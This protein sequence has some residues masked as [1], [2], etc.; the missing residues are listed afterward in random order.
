M[1]WHHRW[2]STP[3][4][5]SRRSAQAMPKG[6]LRPPRAFGLRSVHGMG[7]LVDGVFILMCAV[8]GMADLVDG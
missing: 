7:A 8:H 6:L 5:G 4:S 3:A 1:G 2:R